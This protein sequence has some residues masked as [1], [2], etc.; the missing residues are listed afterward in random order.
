M[1]KSRTTC[2]CCRACSV[3]FKNVFVC[4]HSF[5]RFK[6]TKKTSNTTVVNQMLCL[7]FCFVRR[8]RA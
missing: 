6:Y 5:C 8:V 1:N 7:L 4:Y 2:L 3:D